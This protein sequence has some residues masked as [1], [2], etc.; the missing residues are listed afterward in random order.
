MSKSLFICLLFSLVAQSSECSPSP[1]KRLIIDTDLFSDVDDV[2]ALMLAAT[3]PSIDL[4][5]VNINYPSSYS[6]L[7]ASAVVAHFGHPETPIGIIRPLTN[8]TFFDAWFYELGEYTSKVAYHFSG[9]TLA[10]GRAE[11]AWDPV[12]LYRKV[13]AE[14]PDNSVTIASIGFLDNLSALLNSTAD[15]HSSFSGRD[16]IAT[17]VS[18]LVVMGGTYPQGREFNFYGR[19]ASL[20]AHVINNWKWPVVFAG[21]ELGENVKSGKRLMTEAPDRN[22]ASMAYTWY[23]YGEARSSWDPLTV[24]YAIGGPN[25]ELFEYGNEIGY[26]HIN[27]DGSNVWIYDEDVKSQHFLRLKVS[28]EEASEEVER[29]LLEAAWLKSPNTQQ[30]GIPMVVLRKQETY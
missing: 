5:A 17:K 25:S 10:W 7:A 6:A 14:S 30:N 28:E 18:E 2:G 22:P 1:P 24:L 13:L 16:L 23:T 12:S 29:R 21:F 20:T 26:N 27:E 9:G 3:S 8:D 4:L 11:D 15:T 19:N